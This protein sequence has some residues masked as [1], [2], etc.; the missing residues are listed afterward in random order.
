MSPWYTF[1]IESLE[2]D[3]VKMPV[4]SN[5]DFSVP[6]VTRTAYDYRIRSSSSN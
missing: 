5:H 4:K 3:K 6:F 1:Q 2:P